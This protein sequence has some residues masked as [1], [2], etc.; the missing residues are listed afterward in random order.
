M[1]NFYQ[2]CIL[3]ICC[4]I[5]VTYIQ[6]QTRLLR[7]PDINNSNIVFEYASDIWICNIDGSQPK[8]LTT[9][10]GMERNPYLSNDGKSVCFTG[11]YDGNTDVYMVSIK[12]GNPQRLTWHPGTDVAKG[13]TPD[14]RVMFASGRTKVPVASLE[15]FWS[16][17]KEG[18][19]PERLI[20]PRVTN[21]QFNFDATKFAYQMV[22]PWESEFRHYRGGQN[23]PIRIMDMAT[24]TVEKI[25]WNGSIDQEPVWIDDEVYFM[26]DRDTISNVWSY[27]VTTKQLR[28]RTFFTKFD[29][30]NIESGGDKL[31]IENAGYLHVLDPRSGKVTR[32]D[33]NIQGD[34][35]WAR[36]HWTDVSKNIQGSAISPTGKRAVFSARGDIF[37]VPAKEGNIRNI[38]N[39][40]GVAD[41]DP[42]WSPDGKYISWFSD[43]SGE[44]ELH[45]ADQYGKNI[46]KIPLRKRSFYYSP[47]WSPDSKLLS[48]TDGDRN[49]WLLTINK[50]ELKLIDNE[51]FDHP[52]RTIYPEW[53]PDSKWITYV[54]RLKS[55]FNAVFVYSVDQQKSFQITDGLSNCVSPAWDKGG[56]YIYFLAST[57]Y[58][59]N[60]GWLDMSS[61]RRSSEYGVYVAVLPSDEASP[62]FPKS[63]DEELKKP[64]NKKSDAKKEK[65]MS[66]DSSKVVIDFKHLDQRIIALDIPE[67]SYSSIVAGE[68]N[69][70]YIAELD[71]QSSD[72]K[73][74]LHEYDLKEKELKIVVKKIEAHVLS[75][76]GK[77]IM[78]RSG[79]DW[80]IEDAK[81][82]LK[83]EGKLSLADLQ[84]K[85]D[86][87]LEWKQMFRESI[88]YQRDFFYVENTH[89]LDLKKL[90]ATYSPWMD[91]VNHRADLTYILDIIGGETVRR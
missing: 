59:L 58:G 76:D 72:D 29:T 15:Q 77:K 66:E 56:K 39:S 85:I 23:N 74:N 63:D 50:G 69:K 32:V 53:S 71:P 61:Y 25:P 19:L 18:G 47:I 62:I 26:S 83:G 31:V 86:P 38:T 20:I 37:T 34:L 6:A 80:Q 79:N 27:N 44:Y 33:V 91:Y 4:A 51:G 24:Y 64:E 43:E 35:S 41:R 16:V 81:P 30:K 55:Q 78:Y 9:S 12:G 2:Y 22:Q 89:G 28:Q 60:V 65:D 21:G 87:K 75:F 17:G 13:W 10:Q 3:L 14:D 46:K 68:K 82:E 48:L 54:A 67:K 40:N 84:M 7:N 49:L 36:P 1:Q 90:E 52:Q 8:R 5:H 70:I 45:Y 11:E 57:N 88:R 42:A 73:Y